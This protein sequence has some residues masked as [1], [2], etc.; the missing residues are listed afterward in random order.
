VY[1]ATVPSSFLVWSIPATSG[2]GEHAHTGA[3]HV[4][5][6]GRGALRVENRREAMRHAGNEVHA[7]YLKIRR[8]RD[9]D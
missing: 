3:G 1:G 7:A 8:C 9:I 2:V 5:T 6:T 4:G